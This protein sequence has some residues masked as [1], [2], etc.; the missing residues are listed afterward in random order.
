[1]KCG[2]N[3]CPLQGWQ[4]LSPAEKI[5]QRKDRAA[6]LFN[7]GFTEMQ[8][9]ADLGVSQWTISQDL[10]GLEV[11]SKPHRP[12]GGRPKGSGNRKPRA[13][14]TENRDEEIVALNKSGASRTEIAA[15]LGL[16]DR[17]V[18]RAIEHEKIRSEAEVQ[19]DPK[20]LSLT[21]QQKFAAAIKQERRKLEIEI[22]QQMHVEYQKWLADLM[23]SFREK[24]KHY[25][26]VVSQRKGFMK[27]SMFA[28]FRFALHPDTYK[29]VDAAERNGLVDTWE[30]MK[31]IMLDEKEAPATGRNL[32]STVEEMLK[33]RAE[34]Q[35]Q[36]STQRADNKK[37]MMT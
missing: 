23:V 32:P 6:V 3:G 11:T 27:R 25:N 17:T 19:I 7:Q 12:K 20:T 15:K 10:K 37:R 1:M 24:E 14:T 30:K 26:I 4:D 13:K 36:R 5:K 2:P 18:R 28:R 22:K 29:S 21:A 9:A 34:Y 31:I 16:G 8:I 35:A 33:R